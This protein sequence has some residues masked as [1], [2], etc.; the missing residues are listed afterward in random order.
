MLGK[1]SNSG[2]EKGE[3]FFFKWSSDSCRCQGLLIP[4]QS[5]MSVI[6]EREIDWAPE[7]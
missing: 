1:V 6:Q 7:M 4:T 3:I 5:Q 2:R